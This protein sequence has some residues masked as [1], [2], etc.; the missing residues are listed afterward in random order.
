MGRVCVLIAIVA[1]LVGLA[2]LLCINYLSDPLYFAV[3][4]ILQGP[5]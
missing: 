1:L 4:V 3:N 5:A 2:F